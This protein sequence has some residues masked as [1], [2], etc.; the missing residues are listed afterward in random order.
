MLSAR[1]S[2]TRLD[3][4]ALAALDAADPLAPLRGAF[5][6]P[7][8]VVYL[9]GNSLGALP[10]RAEQIASRVLRQEWG[11]GLVRSWNDAGWH[12]LPWR[13]GAKIAR[14]VGAGEDEVIVT[15]STSA[16]LY[17]VLQAAL[18]LRPGRRSIVSERENFPTD[19]Y[20]AEGAARVRGER[21]R[22][23]LVDSPAHIEGAIDEDCAVLLLTHVNYRDGNMLDMAA[24]TERAHRKGALVAWD[25]SH[26][27]GA[28][29]VELV[30]CEADFAVGCCYKYLN[31]GP[32]APAF[33]FAARRLQERSEQPLSGWWGHAT[34]FD[35]SP[36]FR[37]ADGIARFL[38]GTPP[39][40][41]MAVA[42]AGIDLVLEA[43]IPR[44][45]AKSIQLTE[46]FIELLAQECAGLGLE[47]VGPRDPQRR[48]SQVSVRHPGGYAIMRALIDRGVI[49][50][51]R[52]P[53][54]LRF[55][56][57]P[58]YSRYI[59]AWNAVAVLKDVLQTRAWEQPHYRERHAVT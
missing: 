11:D 50:D 2:A 14:L 25:L 33:V 24:L 19:L 31:G 7:D 58:L 44:L 52:E 39:V 17:K 5:H 40:L 3:L 30:A 53:G 20:I 46:L 38:C 56:F 8:D 36:T 16:N 23:R 15:D 6:L 43:T 29:P 34:P 45:R 59:D 12:R 18:S 4:A 22:L 26:S 48:G 13:L 28:V 57:A 42:E 21:H 37:A 32:V 51:Y 27:A 41:S 49:G 55:G 54:I 47:P 1:T 35:F 9:D 10:K